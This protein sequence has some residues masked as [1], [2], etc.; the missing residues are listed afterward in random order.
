MTEQKLGRDEFDPLAP[1]VGA[2]SFCSSAGFS[3]PHG[4]DMTAKVHKVL[5]RARE[6]LADLRL[7]DLDS[8]DGV[9]LAAGIP[10]Y[11]EI[12]GR[13]MQAAGWQAMMLSPNFLRG[14]IEVVRQRIATGFNDWRDM[15]PGA[16]LHESHT[17]PL[18]ELNFTPKSLYYGAATSAFLLPICVSEF[19]HWT[20]DLE[21][22]RIYAEQAMMAIE[23]ADKYS[24]D[25]TG[26]YRYQTH[27]EQGIKNQGWKDSSDAIVYPD[28]SQVDTPSR[29]GV[30]G[31]ECVVCAGIQ[32][33]RAARR[34]ASA[35]QG[36]HGS[37]EPF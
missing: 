1:A 22:V 4:D 36:H 25:E 3:V 21:M 11:Q 7:Y 8:P 27:S 23:W 6:D 33:I 34:D 20:G 30:A 35:G 31:D 37:G 29:H 12:F 19:W 17:D 13:D 5:N 24:L 32:P 15:R 14:S 10:T 28:G 2:R 16:V 26:F 18:S 9:A